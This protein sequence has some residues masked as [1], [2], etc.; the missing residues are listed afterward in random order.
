MVDRAPSADASAPALSRPPAAA[1]DARPLWVSVALRAGVVGLL[2]LCVLTWAGPALV[3]LA[4]PAWRACFEWLGSDFTLLG[5]TLEPAASGERM[6]R[7]V[8]TLRHHV[9]LGGRV[10]APDARGLAEASTLALQG[11]HGPFV[12][13]CVAAAWPL[14]SGRREAVLRALLLLGPVLLLALIDAPLVLAASIWELIVLHMAPGETTPLLVARD[15][16]RSGGRLGAGVLIGL[17]A[18]LLAR[19]MSGRVH[20]PGGA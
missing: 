3:A 17:G 15:L 18:V 6:L 13:L 14:R 16:L 10:L 19:Q 7:A 8:V 11:L 12:A 2:L 5:L 1:G 9:V 20:R 4:L